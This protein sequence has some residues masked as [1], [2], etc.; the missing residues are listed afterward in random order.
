M[1]PGVILYGNVLS[2]FTKKFDG[3]TG[4][5]EDIRKCRGAYMFK[6]LNKAMGTVFLPAV[7]DPS[8]IY[9]LMFGDMT[10]QQGRKFNI[11][12][13]SSLKDAVSLTTLGFS[14]G[15]SVSIEFI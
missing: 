5:L 9:N 1:G 14:D 10:L 12:A 8:K 3:D 4:N 15:Q 11:I 6:L 2:L 13:D 7:P